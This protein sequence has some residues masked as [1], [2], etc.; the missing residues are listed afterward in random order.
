MRVNS[1]AGPDALP[2]KLI[3][4]TAVGSGNYDLVDD[5]EGNGC[6]DSDGICNLWRKNQAFV[7][8]LS[9]ICP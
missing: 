8:F 4:N 1:F 2:S 9:G 3:E 7:C 6:T 5:T